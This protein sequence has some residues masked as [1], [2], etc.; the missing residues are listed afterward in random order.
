MTR[1]TYFA[2]LHQKSLSGRPEV[3]VLRKK[4]RGKI[5]KKRVDG[6]G[7]RNWLLLKTTNPNPT[8]ADNYGSQQV[9]LRDQGG[10]LG[11]CSLGSAGEGVGCA[12]TPGR[13]GSSFTPLR[14]RLSRAGRDVGRLPAS[15][16]AAAAATPA[17]AAD[18]AAAAT[19]A[20]VGA[21]YC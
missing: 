15:A 5:L 14:R 16:S 21:S 1:V 17:A 9:S 19:A 13:I 18:A 2:I 20:A 6:V 4:R 7:E 10:P 3:K 12:E 8:A 11:A